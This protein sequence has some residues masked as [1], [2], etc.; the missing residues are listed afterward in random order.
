MVNYK[1]SSHVHV[2]LDGK[3]AWSDISDPPKDPAKLLFFS[4]PV[5]SGNYPWRTLN[6]NLKLVQHRG[7]ELVYRY[8]SPGQYVE[9]VGDISWSSARKWH[10]PGKFHAWATGAT[11]FDVQG[12]DYRNPEYAKVAQKEYEDAH[13]PVTGPT[14]TTGTTKAPLADELVEPTE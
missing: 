14:S 2:V 3:N 1:L 13:K 7:S 9:L 5:S 4:G 12:W 10:I 8:V 11:N 6:E